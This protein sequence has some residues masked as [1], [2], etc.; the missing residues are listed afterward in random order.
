[1]LIE[2]LLLKTPNKLVLTV[3][4]NYFFIHHVNFS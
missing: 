4:T 1:M 2:I 3:L